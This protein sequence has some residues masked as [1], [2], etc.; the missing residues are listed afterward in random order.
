[1]LKGFDGVLHADVMDEAHGCASKLAMKCSAK[2][3]RLIDAAS[4]IDSME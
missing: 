4:A 1:M 2:V 3:D